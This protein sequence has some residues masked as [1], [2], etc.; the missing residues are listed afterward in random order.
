MHILIF[1]PVHTSP[2][3]LPSTVQ[4]TD[5]PTALQMLCHLNKHLFPIV[6]GVAIYIITT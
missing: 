5:Q 2:T 1:Y 6:V 4:L 3:Q